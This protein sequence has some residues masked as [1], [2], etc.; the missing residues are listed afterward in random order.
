MGYRVSATYGIF[1]CPGSLT[2]TF[3][4]IQEQ[5]QR[6]FP[7]YP[8]MPIVEDSAT[9][10]VRQEDK[11]LWVPRG[12]QLYLIDRDTYSLEVVRRTFY[13][14]SDGDDIFEVLQTWK[15]MHGDLYISITVAEIESSHR[16]GKTKAALEGGLSECE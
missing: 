2:P 4:R 1:R 11:D 8:V 3:S 12:V 10:K 5:L 16:L 13:I 14:E 15:N 7:D 9:Y 6:T